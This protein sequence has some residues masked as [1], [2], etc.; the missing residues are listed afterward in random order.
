MNRP[1]SAP[2]ILRRSWLEWVRPFALLLLITAPLR[3]AVLD[4]NWVPT[5]SM[6]PTIFEHDLVLVNKL[7]YDLKV[8]FTTSHLALWGNPNRGDIVVFLSPQD[9]GLRLVKH[10]VGLPGDTVQLDREKLRINGRVQPCAKVQDETPLEA[11]VPRGVTHVVSRELLGTRSH[12]ILTLPDRPALRSFG[13]VVV[14]QGQY[15]MMGDSRDDSRD[16]RYFGPVARDRIVGRAL[17][18]LLSIDTQHWMLPRPH[19]F[20]QPLDPIGDQ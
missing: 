11:G 6:L 16:S 8:P 13:P 3:S 15:F 9:S 2:S 14:P 5:G 4:W 20:A 1:R 18:V 12:Y 10:V 17:C 7:S 19:R